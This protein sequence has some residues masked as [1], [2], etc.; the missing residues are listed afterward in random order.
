M[1]DDDVNSLCALYLRVCVLYTL[2]RGGQSPEGI[3][4]ICANK[5][6]FIYLLYVCAFTY[7]AEY[8]AIAHK[9][10]HE[11]KHRHLLERSLN[12]G[13]TIHGTKA[14][15]TR[16][17]IMWLS[18]R[19][20]IHTNYIIHAYQASGKYNDATAHLHHRYGGDADGST[21]TLRTTSD[22]VRKF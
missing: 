1:C 4:F 2:A 5:N 21:R 7:I 10:Q 13:A 19:G 6:I 3:K 22:E 20:D 12:K 9:V 18:S 17:H 15:T 14:V 8:R 16:C 11:V